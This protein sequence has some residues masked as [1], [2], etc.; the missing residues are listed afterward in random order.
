M[1]LA[2]SAQAKRFFIA[3]LAALNDGAVS[4]ADGYVEVLHELERKGAPRTYALLAGAFRN[5]VGQWLLS[6]ACRIRRTWA[7]RH[8]PAVSAW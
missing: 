7:A 8:L 3:A 2:A 4:I 5:R 1:R 6:V